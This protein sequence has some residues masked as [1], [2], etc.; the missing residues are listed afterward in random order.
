MPEIKVPLPQSGMGMQDGAI[1]RWLKA[2]GEDLVEGELLVEVEAAKTM[3]EV[4]ARASGLIEG[5]VAAGETAGLR[6]HIAT[7]K[8]RSAP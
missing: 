2:V 4:P 3:L 7:I 1:V 8:S 5:L 6:S